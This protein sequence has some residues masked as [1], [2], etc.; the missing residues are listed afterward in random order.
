MIYSKKEKVLIWKTKVF[1]V[2]G[3]SLSSLKIS[4]IWKYGLQV[5]LKTLQIRIWINSLLKEKIGVSMLNES[6]SISNK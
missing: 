1:I 6:L 3:H 5:Y 2:K 4:R